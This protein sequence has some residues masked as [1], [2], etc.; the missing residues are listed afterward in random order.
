MRFKSR[1]VSGSQVFA[2]AG[3]NTVSFAVKASAALRKNLLGFAVHRRDPAE[4]QQY[5]MYGFKVFKDLIPV[6]DEDTRVSTFDHPVQSFSW[7]D[8]TAKPDREYEYTFHPIKGKPKNLDRSAKPIAIKVRTEP[9]YSDLEH[10]IFFNRGVAS[11]QAYRREFGNQKPDDLKP[12]AKRERALQW[13]SRDLDDALLK[14]IRSAR[15]NDTLLGCFYE[16]RYRPAVDELKKAIT[17]GVNVRLI[18]DGKVNEHTDKKG[19]FHPSFPRVENRE[20]IRDANIPESAVTLREARRDAIQHNKFIVRLKGKKQ[21]AAEVWTG[22]TNLS[23]GGITGQTNVGHWIRNETIADRFRAYWELLQQDPGSRHGDDASTVRKRNAEFRKAVEAVQAAP[24]SVANVAQG[25]TAIFS[26]RSGDDVLDLYIDMVDKARKS[27]AITLAFGIGEGFKNAIVDN[28]PDGHLIFMLL[29]KKDKPNRNSR[30]P[31]VAI[32]AKQNV[33][34]AWGAFVA[35]PVYQWAA[36]T[37]ARKLQLNQHVAYIHSKFLL[38]DPL[39]ADPIVV[40][41]SAN[42]STASTKENDENMLIIR[43]N[44]RVADIYFTEFNRLFNHYYFRSVMEDRKDDPAPDEDSLFLATTDKWQEKY[45]PGKLKAKR[46][47]LYTDME[48]AVLL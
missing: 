44:Q 30:K 17:R 13:L 31:F 24:D 48:G 4:N 2:V 19:K 47:R 14:F 16:F 46:L 21:R 5:F 12:A 45:K 27:A 39:G 3:V 33:Y 9:L 10:D 15:K 40:T 37:N 35:D 26:P 29:E 23:V 1:V 42:F 8:F 38:R 36:E 22:S 41:G 34:K 11:S 25:V 6:P 43:G 18:V 7:D 28:P 32:N 20:M